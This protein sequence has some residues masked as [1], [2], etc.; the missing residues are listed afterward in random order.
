MELYVSSIKQVVEMCP[1]ILKFSLGHKYSASFEISFYLNSNYTFQTFYIY[2]WFCF[3][4]R[5]LATSP[6]WV[7]NE[8]TRA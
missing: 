4:S 7:G 2:C 8:V 6:D 3:L 5:L 1:D